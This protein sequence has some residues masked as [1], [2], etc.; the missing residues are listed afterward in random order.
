MSEHIVIRRKGSVFEIDIALPLEPAKATAIA[1]IVE[2]DAGVA[3]VT[4][5]RKR[6]LLEVNA[7]GIVT[8]GAMRRVLQELAR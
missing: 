3:E 2:G 8:A 5:G 1:A 7:K 6:R 4:L